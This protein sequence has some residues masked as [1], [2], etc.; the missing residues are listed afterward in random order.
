MTHYEDHGE[1]SLILHQLRQTGCPL[2]FAYQSQLGVENTI[3][4]LL[5]HIYTHLDKPSST[6]RIMLFLLL[7]TP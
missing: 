6:L 7:L 5:N 2:Q 4:Y 3:L 1:S